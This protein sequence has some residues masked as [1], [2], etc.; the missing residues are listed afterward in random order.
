MHLFI[1]A[2]YASAAL[3][4]TVLS[5]GDKFSHLSNKII[6]KSL[7]FKSLKLVPVSQ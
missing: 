1:F 5:I 4:K 3:K 6:S 2:V 7:D